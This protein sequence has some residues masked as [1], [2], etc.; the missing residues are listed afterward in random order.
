MIQQHSITWSSIQDT[1]ARVLCRF[2]SN[3]MQREITKAC[4][5][6]QTMR[7][8]PLHTL[9]CLHFRRW[10]FISKLL[11]FWCDVAALWL[12]APNE[13]EC[14]NACTLV[15][16]ACVRARVPFRAYLRDLS[17]FLLLHIILLLTTVFIFHKRA[18]SARLPAH[19]IHHHVCGNAYLW[20]WL[21]LIFD[22]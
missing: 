6:R 22:H 14:E 11:L 8:L 5:I 13:G 4:E 3:A 10:E 2:K 9:H 12:C 7:V 16:C 20:M 17:H 15:R 21:S 19:T 18:A 1:H